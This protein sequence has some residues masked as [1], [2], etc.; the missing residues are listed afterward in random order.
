MRRR[1]RRKPWKPCIDSLQE[2]WTAGRNFEAQGSSHLLKRE[3]GWKVSAQPLQLSPVHDWDCKSFFSWLHLPLGCHNNPVFMRGSSSFGLGVQHQGMRPKI[4]S[5][6]KVTTC[7]LVLPGSLGNWMHSFSS[8]GL[9]PCIEKV[10]GEPFLLE[11]GLTL[12][13]L[14]SALGTNPAGG[15]FSF[16][17]LAALWKYN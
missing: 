7:L 14:F 4:F 8:P 15:I 5:S 2:R 9:S 16:L 11:L 10:P 17:C 1:K 3:L 6:S 12:L 13:C